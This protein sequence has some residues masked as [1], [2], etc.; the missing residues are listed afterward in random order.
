MTKPTYMG[1]NLE[2]KDVPRFSYSCTIY[3]QTE[4]EYDGDDEGREEWER[5]REEELAE[6]KRMQEEDPQGM[7]LESSGTSNTTY[8]VTIAR[9]PEP[10]V[11]NIGHMWQL[12]AFQPANDQLK[13]D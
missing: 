13:L 8:M 11:E 9:H 12:L 4:V 5:K 1:I 2:D 6:Q 3:E 10:D 7:Q